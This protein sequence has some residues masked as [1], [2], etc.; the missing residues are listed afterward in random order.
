[1]WFEESICEHQMAGQKPAISSFNSVHSLP[2]SPAPTS[3]STTFHLLALANKTSAA[4]IWSTSPSFDNKALIEAAMAS[5]AN[6]SQ[7]Q[8]LYATFY[9]LEELDTFVTTSRKRT[10]KSDKACLSSD[11][12]LESNSSEETFVTKSVKKK[13]KQ[14]AH[15][16]EPYSVPQRPPQTNSSD[17]AYIAEHIDNDN[18][19]EDNSTLGLIIPAKSKLTTASHKPSSSSCKA[20]M[21]PKRRKSLGTPVP[22]SLEIAH[23]ANREL[24]KMKADKKPWKEIKVVWERLTGKQIGESTLSVKYCKM[25]ENF[26]KSDGKIVSP[27]SL[28]SRKAFVSFSSYICS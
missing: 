9:G 10:R 7:Q 19:E 11:T 12:I 2:P 27:K 22:S 5:G 16:D 3:A 18:S 15:D 17:R 4:A 1:V 14:L 20:A 8:S 24:F 6:Q 21:V 13:Q 25:K 23:P 28:K 26:G